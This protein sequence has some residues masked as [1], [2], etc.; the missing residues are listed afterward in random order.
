MIFDK[1][2]NSTFLKGLRH[3][4]VLNFTGIKKKEKVHLVYNICAH[5]F[6]QTPIFLL[7][8]KYLKSR[9]TVNLLSDT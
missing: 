3:S 7:N 2:L 5:F 4:A 8:C 9:R 1:I 6:G